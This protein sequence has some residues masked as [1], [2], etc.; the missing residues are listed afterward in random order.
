[1]A[2]FDYAAKVMLTVL[3]TDRGMS[4]KCGTVNGSVLCVIFVQ[5]HQTRKQ[6]NGDYIE[7]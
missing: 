7:I 4:Y 2:K 5:L 1:M 6:I 3:V